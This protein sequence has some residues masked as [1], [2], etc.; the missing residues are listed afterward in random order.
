MC[1]EKNGDKILSTIYNSMN[2]HIFH[3]IFHIFFVAPLFLTI[4]YIRSNMPIWLYWTLLCL[5][6]IVLV[7]H[8]YRFIVRYYTKS[9]HT[10]IN[11]IHIF[12]IAPLMIYIGYNQKESLRFSYEL[13]L[14]LG[15]ASLG[16]HMFSLVRELQTLDSI[17]T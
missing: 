6:C 11:A 10:W 15:F 1:I 8:S 2:T 3:N 17:N 14:M 4:G 16:Y 12:G 5:G 7:Y 9:T 13:L